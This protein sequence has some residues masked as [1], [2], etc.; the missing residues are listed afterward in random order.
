MTDGA[1]LLDEILMRHRDLAVLVAALLLVGYLVLDLQGAGAGLDHLLGEQIGGL[2]IAEPGIDIGDDGHDMGLVVL[3]GRHELRDLGLVTLRAGLV[4]GA[5]Q[6]AQ[7]AGIGLAEEGVDLGDQRRHRGLLMHRLVGQRA[8]LG[9]QGGDHP[10]G[11]IDIAALGGAEMLLD[12]DHLLLSDEA[13][14][15]A[16]RLGVKARI[17]VIGGHVG[18]HDAGGVA[19]D[20]EPGLE[21]VLQ[22]HPRHGGGVDGIPGAFARLDQLGDG[23]RFLLIAGGRGGALRRAAGHAVRRA[24]QSLHVTSPDDNVRLIGRGRSDRPSARA[25]GPM[26]RGGEGFRPDRNGYRHAQRSSA[27]A[28]RR[29]GRREAAAWGRPSRRALACA[30]WPNDGYGQDRHHAP[31]HGWSDPHQ[32]QPG[33]FPPEKRSERK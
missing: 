17:R 18:A 13:V 30:R 10:A 21:A 12:G 29:H 16:E 25:A 31:P 2:G 24:V 28:S 15:G 7:L 20:V 19:G 9:A 27:S 8:E 26:V 14:P 3:H 11:E 33:R 23:G 22:A 1:D 32:R 5:E 4:D 6:V